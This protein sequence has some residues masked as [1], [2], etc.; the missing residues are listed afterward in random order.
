MS[1]G[2]HTTDSS[3]AVRYKRRFLTCSWSRTEAA[4]SATGS[5]SGVTSSGSERPHMVF[6]LSA[7]TDASTYV[8]PFGWR[9]GTFT[10]VSTYNDDPASTYWRSLGRPLGNF[11]FQ[12]RIA[13]SYVLLLAMPR[14]FLTYHFWNFF[15]S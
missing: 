11:P 2:N 9:T 1:C 13:F 10:I 8:R 14:I 3:V 7:S 5:S 15:Q 12:Q 6:K 4:E